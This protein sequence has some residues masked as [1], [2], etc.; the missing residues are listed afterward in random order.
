M[1]MTIPQLTSLL[2]NVTSTLTDQFGNLTSQLSSINGLAGS[3]I[4]SALGSVLNHIFDPCKNKIASD[5]MIHLTDI[6]L[7]FDRNRRTQYYYNIASDADG[8]LLPA[9]QPNASLILPKFYWHQIF[10]DFPTK[11]FDKIAKKA[12][13]KLNTIWPRDPN[14]VSD[15]NEK[16]DVWKNDCTNRDNQF[17]TKCQDYIHINF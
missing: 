17:L 10:S 13:D 16:N 5:N 7:S 1:Q 11:V 2:P 14:G 3:V 9:D 8:Q 15:I 12:T 6:I 4:N